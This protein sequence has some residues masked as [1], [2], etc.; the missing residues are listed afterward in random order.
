MNE[1]MNNGQGTHAK[2]V[3]FFS[4]KALPAILVLLGSALLGSAPAHGQ[5]QY[6]AGQVREVAG[7]EVQKERGRQDM[8]ELEAGRLGPF[9]RFTVPALRKNVFL[10]LEEATAR[11]ALREVVHGTGLKL[12]LSRSGH[13]ANGERAERVQQHVQPQPVPLKANRIQSPEIEA[14]PFRSQTGT[15]AGTVIDSA[16]GESLP[17]VNIV[18]VGTQR[19]T[20]TNPEGEY[21]LTGVEEG[22]YDVRASF[23]GYTP[24][25]VEEVEVTTGETVTVNF[26]LRLS[27]VRLG[28]VVA[29]GYGTAQ[30]RDVTGSVG[31]IDAADVTEVQTVDNVAQLLQGRVPGLN[32]GVATEADGQTGLEVR[33]RNSIQASNAPLLV[34]DGVPYH[35]G[36]LSD[37]NPNDVESIDVL[38]G[39]SAAA[40][41]GA[42]A[43]AGVIEVTTKRGSGAEPTIRFKSS[44]GVATE[45][46][47]VRPYGPEAYVRQRQAVAIRQYPNEPE[48]Y[49]ADPRNLPD[50]I[51]LE[52]WK[53]LGGAAGE[54]VEIWLSRIELESN[55]IQ[56]YME[57]N[58]I[59]WYDRV[60][61]DAALRQ[62][63]N[64]SLSG[65]PEDVSYYW[66]LGYVDN[67]GQA[68]GDRFR[69]LR[70]RLNLEATVVDW[71]EVG[72]NSQYAYRNEGFLGANATQ[73]VYA[74]P[75]GDMYEE[76]GSLTWYPHNDQTAL[77][78][79]IYTSQ[80]GR[81]YK[82]NNS[83]LLATIRAELV[84]LPVGLGYEV[85]W[86]ND[87]D[88]RRSYLF[89]PSSTP[90][91]EPAGESSRQEITGH[92]WQLDNIL[93][94]NRMLAGIHE[95]DATFLFNLEVR[96]EWITNASNDQFPIETLGYSGLPLGAN[97]NV[98]SE[99]SRATANALMGRLNYRL[100]DRYLFT[101]SYRRDGYSA[102][103]QNHPYAYFPSAAFAWR[104]SEEPFFDVDPISNLKLRL[105]WGKNGN[106]SIGTYA[107][108]QRL[109]AG[110]YIYGSQSTMTIGS[111]SLP[112]RDL[113]WESTE[114]YNLGVDF[115][116]FSERLSGSLGVYHMSTTNLLLERSLPDVTGYEDIWSN[117]GKVVNQ[118]AE[119]SLSSTNIL[120]ETFNWTS[121][122]TF[123]MNRNEIKSLY[124][125]MV[126]VTNA[127]GEVVGQREASDRQNGWFI[128]EALDRIYDYEILGVWQEDEAGEA[129][130]YGMKP[131]DFKLRDVNGDGTL[132]PIED[133]TFQGY[134]EP[135]Y[136]IGLSNN[137]SYKDLEVSF[138]LTSWLGHYTAHNVHKHTGWRYGRMN[139]RAYPYWTPD[140][141]TTEWARLKSRGNDPSFNYWEETSFVKLQN[142]S[143][144]YTV[145]DRFAGGFTENLR[146]FLNAR[147]VYALS[148][149]DG[150]DPETHEA[151]PRLYTLGLNLSL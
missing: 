134:T 78:P 119:L 36:D 77:N 105:S 141:P 74:S 149:F 3:V 25:T 111:N 129:A 117:L 91:G 80:S 27:T 93:T 9:S 122:L 89:N 54:P 86:T 101:V 15:I 64:M 67:A 6:A 109:G 108:L 113:Q 4:L 83:N 146:V 102:F 88:Y 52:E 135:R 26:S 137:F 131:G 121:D 68:T 103:G 58:T 11:E 142:L 112:N 107:A 57:G 76:D 43:A 123:S 127:E 53:N 14:R 10:H 71:L 33:G 37:I 62:N 59:D 75:Y 28:E 115:G 32:A 63:Y 145:P 60:Y 16:S 18:L 125:T 31:S 51:T 87:F 65:H 90:M 130:Q 84:D 133:K 98:G 42:S 99:D 96:N 35:Q 139:F 69:T 29:I 143:V 44:L 48:H 132:S 106:R 38:K 126:P 55:E 110:K 116:L 24:Q 17:G 5:V 46:E 138:L 73:A 150:S 151:T 13:V 120:N 136:R 61:R 50:D 66:S 92:V 56:N 104:L 114:Q 39:A 22:T 7:G 72:L 23:V 47:A 94:W 81:S 34:V 45:G 21:E 97:P 128:G 82:W 19:G 12:L 1:L 124:G 148:G 30:K 40:V 100:L 2:R 70:T 85:R 41:Y 49:F 118:G 8:A 95:F 140:N 147:N 144:A 79:F 20:S